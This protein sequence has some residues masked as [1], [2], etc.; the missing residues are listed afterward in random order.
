L[1]DVLTQ[2]LI[3]KKKVGMQGLDL[4]GRLRPMHMKFCDVLLQVMQGLD[5]VLCM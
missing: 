1:T 5:R 4:M 3:K 2:G